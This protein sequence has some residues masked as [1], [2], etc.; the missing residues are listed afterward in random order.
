MLDKFAEELHEAREKSGISLQQM[1]MKTRIDIKFLEAIDR[2]DFAFLPDPYVKAFLKDYAKMVGMDETK[3]IQKYEA[4]KKGKQME[5]RALGEPEDTSKKPAP[6]K[7]VQ[8]YDATPPQ[9][10]ADSSSGNKNKMLYFIIGGGLLFLLLIYLLFFRSSN[11]IV[12][13]EK[14]IEEIIQDNQRFVEENPS[15]NSANNSAVSDSMV[16]TVFSGDTSWVKIILDD[17]KAEEFI[18]FPNSQ[19]T[20]KAADNYK[21]TLGNSGGIKFRLNNNPVNYNGKAGTLSYVQ[22]D[23][24]GL[25]N[26]KNPPALDKDD[27]AN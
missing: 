15:N 11:E 14:P 9:P 16:L 24:N 1:A 26:L 6:R 17:I 18:L 12:V 23:K 19:K 25:T 4:A 13:E 20:I 10:A 2:G 8:T 3:I 7:S 27:Q 22:I 21:I 5:E